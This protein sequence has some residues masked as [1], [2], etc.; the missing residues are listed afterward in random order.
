MRFFFDAFS[1]KATPGLWNEEFLNQFLLRAPGKPCV[2]AT[3]ASTATLKK[4]LKTAG[5]EL[6][7]QLGFGGKRESTRAYRYGTVVTI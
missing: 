3:Y 4:A 5:F 6:K 2:F 7:D 1:S